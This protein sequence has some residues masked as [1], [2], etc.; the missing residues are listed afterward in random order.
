MVF[1]IFIY[2][3]YNDSKESIQLE[4]R[5]KRATKIT[6]PSYRQTQH[7]KWLTESNSNLQERHAV[8]WSTRPGKEYAFHKGAK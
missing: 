6:S 5:E 2:Y 3:H 1:L 8:S 7:V 4:P